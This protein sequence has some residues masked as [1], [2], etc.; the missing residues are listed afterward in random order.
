GVNHAT[1]PDGW[2]GGSDVLALLAPLPAAWA[3]GLAARGRR[4]ELV[5]AE[6]RAEE[7]RL[8][9]EWREERA[10]TGE[11]LRI[12]R[13]MHDVVAHSLTLLVVH[14]ETMRA[15]GGELPE[16]ASR[17]VDA[18]AA[19]GRQTTAE[20]R[21]LLGYLRGSAAAREAAPRDPAPRLG[22][23]PELVEAAR[24]A[25]T[26][27]SLSL[28]ADAELLPGAVQ[29]AGYRIVRE[30]LANARRH[31]PGAPVRVAAELVDGRA[32]RFEVECGPPPADHP[33]ARG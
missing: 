21:E 24:R 12:A 3:L 26:P 32:A 1:A 14:A 27:V 31:A 25:G 19:A 28:P 2:R 18:M 9:Q 15:R 11:R 5:A 17:S 20:L 33:G 23:V 22:A 29:S 16:W 13:D 30:C 4:E 8:A 7:A 6:R 10:A